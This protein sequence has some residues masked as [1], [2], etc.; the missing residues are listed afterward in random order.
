MGAYNEN[1][2]ANGTNSKSDAGSAY[3]FEK[4]TD[5]SWNEVQKIVASDR[6]ESDY[7]GHSV[8]ISGN[9][10]I[11]GAF[12]EDHGANGTSDSTTTDPDYLSAAG[13]AYIFK[14]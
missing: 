5:G 7:F 14:G 8:S 12:Y 9:Y 10:A 3:I 1:Q 2:D 13:S 11:V 4:D 6:Q